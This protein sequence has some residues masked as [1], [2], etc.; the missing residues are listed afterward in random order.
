M[1]QD[2]VRKVIFKR[3]DENRV[4]LEKDSFRD[5][6]FQEQY[7][8]AMDS[9][10]SVCRTMDNNPEN[11]SNIISFCGDRG[12]GKSSCMRTMREI[13]KRKNIFTIDSTSTS[14]HERRYQTYIREIEQYPLYTLEVID[15]SFFDETHNI[16][17]LVISKMFQ[18]AFGKEKEGER[19]HDTYSDKHELLRCFNCVKESMTLLAKER[20]EILDNIE[21]LDYLAEGLRL[22]KNVE[23]LFEEFL[24]YTGKRS[25]NT[26]SGRLIISIDDLDLNV[27]GGYEMLEQIRKYLCNRHCVILIALKI[28]QM[29]KVVQNALYADNKSHGKIISAGMCRDMAEKY[30]TKMFP[31][32]HRVQMP[33]VSDIVDFKLELRYDYETKDATPND[34][35]ETWESVKE[36][37]VSLIFLKTRYLFY[38]KEHEVSQIIPN[39]LRSL[40]HLLAMLLKMN[41]FKKGSRVSKE[42]Q[43]A[44][45]KYF[46][47]DWTN[48]LPETQ[49]AMV[50]EIINYGDVSTKN[51]YILTLLLKQLTEKG[52]KELNWWNQD[53]RSYN[54]SVGDVLYV[55]Q[56]LQETGHAE[57]RSLLFFLQSYYSICLYE[58]Y[59]ELVGEVEDAT[60]GDAIYEYQK[61]KWDGKKIVLKPKPKD[62]HVEIYATDERFNEI[63]KLQQF[64]GG[65]YYTYEPGTFLP[66]EQLQYDDV[67]TIRGAIPQFRV[68]TDLFARDTRNLD[69]NDI[70]F[71]MRQ[72]VKE[73]MNTNS[74]LKDDDLKLLRFHLCEFFALT[75]KMTQTAEE[76]GNK[77]YRNRSYPYYLSGF[78]QGNTILVFDV[79]SIFAN[80]INLKFAYNRFNEA[81]F[82]NGSTSESFY[83]IALKQPKS[84][85]NKILQSF[86]DSN[87]KKKY[88]EPIK[89]AYA[90]GR[91]A[92]AN[93]IRNVDVHVALLL[94]IKADRERISKNKYSGSDNIGRLCD[95]FDTISD[96]KMQ[97][98]GRADAI[99]DKLYAVKYETLLHQIKKALAD[100]QSNISDD[101]EL[102]FTPYEKVQAKRRIERHLA[103]EAAK[104]KLFSAENNKYPSTIGDVPTP[105]LQ[106]IYDEIG[107]LNWA[108]DL[109]GKTI[110]ESLTKKTLNSIPSKIRQC[111]SARRPYASAKE[112]VDHIQHL[113]EQHLVIPSES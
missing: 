35:S 44:F 105:Y 83:Q 92:S 78:K 50:H 31:H 39:N 37:V 8:D 73:L 19:S 75:S 84:L 109:N 69:A 1:S 34:N 45:K 106:V 42:N 55:I 110:K 91:M 20:K 107:Q 74:A 98:Y 88:S 15:P 102:L 112:F 66:K 89:T 12:E 65:T 56:S 111:I 54:V 43:V 62:K 13:L 76:D 113:V 57:L 52:I 36:A 82:G 17:D 68:I 72:Y 2:N 81:I 48:V 3:G 80:V 51:H 99:N 10:I 26:Y 85:L 11:V 63:G 33:T 87:H 79:L 94:K 67:Q 24:K 5:S 58:Y 97:L 70:F 21:A 16:L 90:I 95:F 101:F 29:L 32:E 14:E 53:V 28:E 71:Y 60:N 104:R 6:L 108:N 86:V 59:D 25:N 41:D 61:Y 49:Q 100:V 18:E 30:I 96:V 40:R 22:Q 27:Q 9:F 77:N 103:T 23:K 64:V 4:V 46:F 7:L 93:I 47:N 38:N